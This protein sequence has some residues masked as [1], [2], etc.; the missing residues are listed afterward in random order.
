[1]VSPPANVSSIPTHCLRLG[2]NIL[3]LQNFRFAR[4]RFTY[5]VQDP[6]AG[7]HHTKATSS[8]AGSDTSSATSPALAV[9]SSVKN[10]VSSQNDASIPNALKH[11]CRTIARCYAVSRMHRTRLCL[12][13]H[14]PDNWTIHPAIPLPVI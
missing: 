7:C 13:H 12:N 6:P 9:N 10:S 4:Y 1:M 2:V 3:M 5:T 8:A 11:Q 14:A